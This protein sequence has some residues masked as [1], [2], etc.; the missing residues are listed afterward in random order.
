[1]EQHTARRAVIVDERGG[2]SNV[3]YS[4]GWAHLN[5]DSSEK[6]GPP[7]SSGSEQRG[8]CAARAKTALL[9][10]SIM[11]EV[12]LIRRYVKTLNLFLF[13]SLFSDAPT[14]LMRYFAFFFLILY[15]TACLQHLYEEESCWWGWTALG[16]F[17]APST[18]VPRLIQKAPCCCCHRHV[19]ILF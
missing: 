18:W 8:P 17:G 19:D 9:L 1:M 14:M 12:G 7:A 16:S 15:S 11:N 13:F 6:Q 2:S 4:C 10:H 5:F 3:A